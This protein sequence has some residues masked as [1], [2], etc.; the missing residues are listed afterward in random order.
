LDHTLTT[1]SDQQSLRALRTAAVRATR[2]PSVHN[3]QPWRFVIGA[4]SLEIYADWSRQLRVLDPR[5][6]QLTISC[7]CALFNARVALAAHDAAVLVDRIPDGLRPDLLARVVT[8]PE[9]G[10]EADV[11]LAAL[12]SAI[13]LRR[14]NRREFTDEWVPGD[15]VD[16]LCAVAVQ[17]GA[18]VRRIET[19]DDRRATAALSRGAE[20]FERTDPAYPAE[21]RAWT[22]DRLDR[23]DGVPSVAVPR[24][25]GGVADAVP[26][27]DFDARGNGA[28]PAHGR[29]AKRQCLLLLGADE[30]DTM[31]WLRVGEALER[32]LLEVARLGYAASPFTQVIEVARTNALLRETLK[33]TMHPHVLLRVGKAPETSSTRR[34]RLVDVLTVSTETR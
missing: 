20:Q 2:A 21:L 31:A 32:V 29:D 14:T 1:V 27:R 6:R 17:E 7:G 23:E 5:G 22:T 11:A 18:V 25:D 28:L 33:L 15:V 3:T 16:R 13:E 12:A 10:G 24:T 9:K 26:L 30:D 4:E 19:P 8:K 34:R